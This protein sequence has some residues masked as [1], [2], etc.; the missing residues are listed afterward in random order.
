MDREVVIDLLSNDHNRQS[1][2]LSSLLVQIGKNIEVSDC[3][4]EVILSK[5]NAGE[6]SQANKELAYEVVRASLCRDHVSSLEIIKAIKL[7]LGYGIVSF[8]FDMQKI[9]LVLIIFCD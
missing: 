9:L 1:T 3:I 8:D 6:M 2:A 4:V 7:D 5:L